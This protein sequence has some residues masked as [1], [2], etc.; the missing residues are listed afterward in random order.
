MGVL[1]RKNIASVDAKAYFLGKFCFRKA[2]RRTALCCFL[3]SFAKEWFPDHCFFRTLRR[4]SSLLTVS[5][6]ICETNTFQESKPSHLFSIK[7]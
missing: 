3:S 7:N 6:A 4:N 1:F 2:G 5:F